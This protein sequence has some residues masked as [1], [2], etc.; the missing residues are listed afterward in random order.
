MSLDALLAKRLGHTAQR[1]TLTE[2]IE[3]HGDASNGGVAWSAWALAATAASNAWL[4]L[5]ERGATL[6]RTADPIPKPTSYR[7]A[8]PLERIAPW[9]NAT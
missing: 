9:P 1:T 3:L 8:W 7:D 2:L 4:V 6:L 5:T